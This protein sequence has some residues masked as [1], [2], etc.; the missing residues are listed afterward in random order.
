VAQGREVAQL[1]FLR[2]NLVGSGV[3]MQ[4]P[5]FKGE[6]GGT[7]ERIAPQTKPGS[8]AISLIAPLPA[9]CPCPFHP[10]DSTPWSA[11]FAAIR[12]GRL[13]T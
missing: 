12:M 6:F 13:S 2:R 5:Y 11:S 7:E 8:G 10:N 1:S 9:P 4:P 3:I